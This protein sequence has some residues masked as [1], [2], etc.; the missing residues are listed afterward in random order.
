MSHPLKQKIAAVRLRA[1]L[2]ILVNSLAWSVA[3]IVATI[4]LTGLFDYLF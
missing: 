3:V 4:L 2:V 1:V